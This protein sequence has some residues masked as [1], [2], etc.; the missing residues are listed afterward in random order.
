MSATDLSPEEKEIKALELEL[1]EAQAEALRIDNS[2]VVLKQKL[3]DQ[4]KAN[5]DEL[6]FQRLQKEHGA[7][8]IARVQTR[9]GSLYLKRP[10]SDVYESHQGLLREAEK[11][12]QDLTELQRDLIKACRLHPSREEFDRI[13]GEQP[14]A[15]N[16]L[17]IATGK[18]VGAF[19]TF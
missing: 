2:A 18:L 6:L 12:A 1:A 11:K 17:S 5:E 9:L 16:A 3:A 13:L 7:E 15:I 8:N 4:K 10:S 14:G 19:S